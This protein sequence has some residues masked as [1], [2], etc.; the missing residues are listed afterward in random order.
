MHTDEK[1][2]RVYDI[3]QFV[4]HQIVKP[5]D[6][7]V[8]V[9]LFQIRNVSR[10]VKR[11]KFAC[12]RT[13]FITRRRQARFFGKSFQSR[14]VLYNRGIYAFFAEIVFRRRHAFLDERQILFG[15]EFNRV[16]VRF[17]IKKAEFKRVIYK[18]LRA[19]GKRFAFEFVRDVLVN[20]N[21]VRVG[22]E[23]L[24]PRNVSFFIRKE[25]HAGIYFE[26]DGARLAVRDVHYSENARDSDAQTHG[27]GESRRHG[28]LLEQFPE[29]RRHACRYSR[30]YPL[31]RRIR[32][33]FANGNGRVSDFIRK[34]EIFN[35]TLGFFF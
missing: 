8:A 1:F 30:Q 4:L 7:V 24:H 21:Y 20:E 32:I 34:F 18:N 29:K 16:F 13:E 2:R 35:R 9:S 23:R 22:I 25:Q 28:A 5:R 27:A 26:N 12:R 10:A 11:G 19:F 33:L 15:G 14:Y 3:R 31:F 17:V 6:H